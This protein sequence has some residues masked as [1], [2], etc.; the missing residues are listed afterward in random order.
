[1]RS[2]GCA[3]L[4]GRG[5][6][7]GAKGPGQ[8][9]LAVKAAGRGDLRQ[10]FARRDQGLGAGNAAMRDPAM[11]A[12]ARAGAKAALQVKFAQIRQ[13]RQ[14]AQVQGLIQMRLDMVADQPQPAGRQ[15]YTCF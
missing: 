8:V 12:D 2:K 3:I 7:G 4:S 10:R 13:R 11:R 9:A 1:M 15:P 5:A 14:I 6:G